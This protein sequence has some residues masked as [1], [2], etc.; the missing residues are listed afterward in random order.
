VSFAWIK[1]SKCD[2]S[3]TFRT[4]P[5]SKWDLPTAA[6]IDAAIAKKLETSSSI[7]STSYEINVR[8]V[9]G[10]REIGAGHEAM[11][12]FSSCTTMYCLSHNGYNKINKTVLLAYKDAAQK[13]MLRAAAEAKRI[14]DSITDLKHIRVSIDG[15][16]QKRGHNSRNSVVTAVCGDKCVDMEVLTKHCNGCKMWRSKK[17]TSQNQCWLVDHQR[18]INHE[19]SSG[20]MESVGAV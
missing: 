13:G 10:F 18:K 9:I 3:K 1:C 6:V 16:W 15:S 2:F 4:S 11:K 8:A 5:K 14:N 12:S 7:V 17:G 19:T 20:S